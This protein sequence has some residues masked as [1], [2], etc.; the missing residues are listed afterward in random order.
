MQP[1]RR[2][3]LITLSAVAGLIGPIFFAI[4]VIVLGYLWTGYNHVTQAISELGATNAPNMGI[5]AL[6]FAILGILTVIF[7]AGLIILQ[8]GLGYVRRN[9]TQL[10]I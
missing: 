3:R 2:S 1:Q 9:S 4:I 6:N 5:Q 10:W 7:A 8:W